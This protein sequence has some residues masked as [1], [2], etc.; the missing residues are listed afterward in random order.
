MQVCDGN[1]RLCANLYANRAAADM[2]TANYS[3]A[4][5]DCGRA[6]ELHPHHTKAMLR[7]ARAY[8]KMKLY[9]AALKALQAAKE[10]LF[11]VAIEPNILAY[12][13]EINA[14]IRG[15]Q[16]LSGIGG[17]A[18]STL[19][20]VLD[21]IEDCKRKHQ[22][23]L[24]AEEDSRYAQD[25]DYGD[26]HHDGCDCEDHDESDFE[27]PFGFQQ[28]FFY[29]VYGSSSPFGARNAGW[30]SSRAKAAPV[31]P[32]PINYYTVLEVEQSADLNEIRRAYRAMALIHHPDK[33][34]DAEKFKQ[35]GEAHVA[36]SD[37]VKRLDHDK[38]LAS[39]KRRY[40]GAP[41]GPTGNW[42]DAK[43]KGAR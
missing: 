41:A 40:G 14:E 28:E 3:Q 38:A 19:Q 43:R 23:E 29:G 1:D 33:G 15:G 24:R 35:I 10:G 22:A 42:S 37:P 12:S 21:E 7:K 9:P 26:C 34:G 25:E 27:D 11:L 30:S 13:H 4:V 6:L 32:A 17:K 16:Q 39:H 2:A 20:S 31:P 36:L 18:E 5:H 8:Q